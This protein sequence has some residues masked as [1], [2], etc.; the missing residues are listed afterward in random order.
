MAI[1]TVPFLAFAVLACEGSSTSDSHLPSEDAGILEHDAS[2]A[3]GDA[4]PRGSE[5]SSES[6]ANLVGFAAQGASFRASMTEQSDGL[7]DIVLGDAA[8]TCEATRTEQFTK[9]LHLTLRSKGDMKPGTFAVVDDTIMGGSGDPPQATAILWNVYDVGAD[10]CALSNE[11]AAISGGTITV[12]SA[13]DS[14]V[15]GSVELRLG[16]SNAKVEGT[17]RAAACSPSREVFACPLTI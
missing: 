4:A 16:R 5:A 17:F 11:D 13:S 6:T 7:L 12:T 8:D 3:V 14:I 1:F 10:L 9:V 15:E 2:E